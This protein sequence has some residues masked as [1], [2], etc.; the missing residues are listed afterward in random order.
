[1]ND[2]YSDL[3]TNIPNPTSIFTSFLEKC[4]EDSSNSDDLAPTRSLLVIIDEQVFQEWIE[5]N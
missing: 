5:I 3:S 1:M 4:F 2:T